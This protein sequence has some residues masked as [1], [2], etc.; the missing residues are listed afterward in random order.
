M[1][2]TPP[3]PPSTLTSTIPPSIRFS[4]KASTVFSSSNTAPRRPS[5]L[6]GTLSNHSCPTHP[7]QPHRLR[8]HP[9]NNFHSLSSPSTQRTAPS[10]MSTA[11]GGQNG[12][13]IP[14]IPLTSSSTLDTTSSSDHVTNPTQPSIPYGPTT[15]TLPTLTHIWL[16]PSISRLPQQNAT[17]SHP[18][19]GSSWPIAALAWASAPQASAPTLANA[20][21]H[22]PHHCHPLPPLCCPTHIHSH[23]PHLCPAQPLAQ[24]PTSVAANKPENSKL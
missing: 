8:S 11:D 19:F 17:P 15:L 9:H 22:V 5:D 3:T 6:V 13:S 23:P 10:V 16:D 7:F 18:T 14:L 24:T 2:Q 21:K 12:T 4:N 1:T 20:V